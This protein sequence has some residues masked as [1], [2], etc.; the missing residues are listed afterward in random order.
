LIH[1]LKR[2][3]RK[4][5]DFMRTI[6]LKIG[7][8]LLD[9]E[10]TNR[11]IYDPK[12][13]IDK[14]Q[15]KSILFMRDD[16][17]IG[18]TIVSTV[19]FREIKK[20]FPNLKIGIVVRKNVYEIIENNKNLDDIYIYSKKLKE[21]LKLS[22]QIKTEKYD[23]LV[24]LNT[25]LKVKQMLFI[26]RC[27]CKYN[28]GV[29]KENWNMFDFNIERIDY[30]KHIT[31]LFFDLL[32][33]LGIGCQDFS[34]DIEC[35]NTMLYLH[36]L[37][38]KNY[39]VFN[40]YGASKYRSFN[41]ENIKKIVHI[42]MK[43]INMKIILIGPFEKKNE[44][45]KV[46]KEL[47]DT[48]VKFIYTKSML[49]VAELVRYSRVVVTPDTSIVHIASAFQ[50]TALCIYRKKINGTDKNY[51]FWGP[52]NKNAK[53]IYVEQDISEDEEIDINSLDFILLEEKI[54]EIKEI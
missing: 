51:L 6:R 47:K 27:N 12:N 26:S 5:H 53:I 35:S 52:N 11:K 18:D 25:E 24:D 2:I 45:E 9:K 31:C 20:K 36:K 8:K 29:H 28:L 3:N 22:R 4:V 16:G 23:L 7:K 41:I 13:I 54:D 50:V 44:L 48:K 42:L 49:E 34:Y 14:Y 40:P 43:K 19:L 46:I 1:K 38:K 39:V 32:K 21:I 17:K 30:N 37:E 15:I 10:T 33:K